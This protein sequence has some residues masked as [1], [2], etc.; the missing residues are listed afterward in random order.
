MCVFVLVTSASGS[1]SVASASSCRDIVYNGYLDADGSGPLPAIH[2]ECQG[3]TAYFGKKPVM[4]WNFDEANFEDSNIGSVD[5]A[6]QGTLSQSTSMSGFGKTVFY[7]NNADHRIDFSPQSYPATSTTSVW[8]KLDPTCSNNQILL[9]GD[10]NTYRLTDFAY[11]GAVYLG[12]W[13]H[14]STGGTYDWCNANANQWKHYVVVD[15]GSEIRVY[16]DGNLM[17]HNQQYSYSSL[18]SVYKFAHIGSF[19]GWGTNGYHGHA[20]D[21][22]IWDYAMTDAEIK[23]LFDYGKAGKPAVFSS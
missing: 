21:L 8:V 14:Q 9:V 10:Q 6:V 17:D 7:N 4:Y 15:T 18:A 1:S 16:D 2:V 23:A 12:G 13:T 19:A 20:D 11:T 3:S 5:G 22:A